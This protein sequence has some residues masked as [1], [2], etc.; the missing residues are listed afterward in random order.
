MGKVWRE[1]TW[2]FEIGAVRLSYQTDETPDEFA[3]DM[4]ISRSSLSHWWSEFRDGPQ[5][6]FP[7]KGD[8]KS[9]MQRL[10]S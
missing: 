1:F 6:T 3:E 4:G 5:R 2:K 7:A 10:L 8:L 9:G